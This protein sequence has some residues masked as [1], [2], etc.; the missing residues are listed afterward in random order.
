MEAKD[1]ALETLRDTPPWEW[2]ER[3]SER[4]LAVLRDPV[5]TET[6]RLLAAELAGDFTVVNDDI[7]A[8][9]LS[10]LVD[11][12]ESDALR[13]TAAISLGPVLE[14]ADEEGFEESETAV[15]EVPIAQET[16]ARVQKVLRE[17]YRDPA[18]PD[19][20]R[21]RVLE[22]SVRAEQDWHAEAIR[23]AARQSSEPWLL[24]AVFCM[25]FVPGFEK[26]I[27]TALEDP[28]ADIRQEAVSAAGNW[29][30]EG[31]WP[32]ILSLIR[33]PRTEKSMLLAAIEAAASIRPDEALDVLGGLL[34]SKDEEIAEATQEALTMAEAFR[35]EA[36]EEF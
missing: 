11:S 31:A 26:E 19:E 25:R 23:T 3:A 16:F 21:R 35:E 2:P 28:N 20:L 9:L 27:L 6:D 36:E 22:A 30:V 1:I 8:T 14:Y 15:S 29:Q 5:A 34:E 24:T 4:L 17:L 18:T 10:I 13:A 33:S 32:H 12:G 7:V